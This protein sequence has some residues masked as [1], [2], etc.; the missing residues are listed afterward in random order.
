MRSFHPIVHPVDGLVVIA[1]EVQHGLAHGLGG[2]G[3]GVD[4]GTTDDLAHFNQRDLLAQLGGID[5]G[6]L[7]C[8]ARADDD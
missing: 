6:T 1:G 2:D 7:S 3:S 8:G 4:T 5:G